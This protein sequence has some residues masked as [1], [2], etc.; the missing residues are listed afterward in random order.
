MDNTEE[1]WF[2][3]DANNEAA[4]IPKGSWHFKVILNGRAFTCREVSEAE[5]KRIKTTA[6]GLAPKV[7]AIQSE[8][9]QNKAKIDRLTEALQDPDCEDVDGING[10]IAELESGQAEIEA[11]ADELEATQSDFFDQTLI[12]SIQGWDGKIPLT[13]ELIR[14]LS[15]SKKSALVELVL[16]GSTLGGGKR[17]STPPRSRR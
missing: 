6:R 10:Q 15:N 4:G 14:D 17:D 1:A 16:S 8:L 11:R 7:R 9:A 5:L 12:S 13:P 2:K 3:S